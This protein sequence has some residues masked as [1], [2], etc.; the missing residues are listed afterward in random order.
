VFSPCALGAVLDDDSVPRLRAPIVAGAANNQLAEPRHGR[1]LME[2]G[3]L[4]APDY[5]INAGGIINLYYEGPT[6]R[7]A[8]VEAHLRRIGETLTTIFTRARDELRPTHEI[9]DQM[10]EAIFR[11]AV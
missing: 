9:A 3:V 11:R 10:A 4:Y 6:R 2:R 8:T 1:L 7:W 5:A